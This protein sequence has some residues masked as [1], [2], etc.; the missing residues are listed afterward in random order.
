MISLYGRDLGTTLNQLAPAANNRDDFQP[1]PPNLVS[2]PPVTNTLMLR[3]LQYREQARPGQAQEV[4]IG[5]IRHPKTRGWPGKLM[6]VRPAAG[7]C[8][9]EYPDICRP[10]WPD[11]NCP[12]EPDECSGVKHPRPDG[13]WHTGLLL[14]FKDMDGAVWARGGIRIGVW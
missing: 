14:R 5:L 9:P 8:R 11:P 4:G 12:E 7:R 1:R 2:L 3:L 10:A 13:C 6:R